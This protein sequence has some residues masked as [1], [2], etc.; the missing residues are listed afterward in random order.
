[1]VTQNTQDTIS[2]VKFTFWYINM[3]QNT[4]ITWKIPGTIQFLW[5]N[6]F[7]NCIQ[8]CMDTWIFYI[9]NQ[10][11]ILIHSICLLHARWISHISMSQET[12][13]NAKCLTW[14]IL[15]WKDLWFLQIVMML[16]KKYCKM[17][18]WP[19]IPPP[20]P[21]LQANKLVEL[22][23]S[24]DRSECERPSHSVC[25]QLTS[26]NFFSI[27]WIHESFIF[28]TN[29][30]S[31]YIVSAFYTPVEYPIFRWVRRPEWMRNVWLHLYLVKPGLIQDQTNEIRWLFT[32]FSLP[33]SYFH[34]PF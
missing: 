16:I 29:Q 15:G 30:K 28:I 17:N 9:Y 31:S 26:Q 6:H 5:A 8:Y 25:D 14:P 23:E 19:W 11:K 24:G 20:P 10:S 32:D 33:S 18:E 4:K 13:M 2:H 3:L 7:P 22:A 1:M 21:V 27:V 12:G 34:C